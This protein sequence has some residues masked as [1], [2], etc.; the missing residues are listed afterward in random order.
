VVLIAARL[1]MYQVV[2]MV[3]AVEKDTR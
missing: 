3:L 2:G 1:Y